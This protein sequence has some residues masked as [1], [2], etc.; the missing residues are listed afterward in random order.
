MRIYPCFLWPLFHEGGAV[1]GFAEER[2]AILRRN[3]LKA[4]RKIF[5]NDSEDASLCL[6][7]NSHTGKSAIGTSQDLGP[8]IGNGHGG[9]ISAIPDLGTVTGLAGYQSVPGATGTSSLNGLSTVQRW[10]RSFGP[11]LSRRS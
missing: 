9:I 7:Q 10:G 4:R 6:R 11:K 8:L 1:T 2:G 3:S 5:D